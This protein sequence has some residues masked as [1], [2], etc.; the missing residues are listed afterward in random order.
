[1]RVSEAAPSVERTRMVGRIKDQG[2]PC[3]GIRLTDY[4]PADHPLR[5][6]NAGSTCLSSARCSHHPAAAGAVLRSI[7]N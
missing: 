1:M 4:V 5:H 7:P 6:I 3:H 2:Q